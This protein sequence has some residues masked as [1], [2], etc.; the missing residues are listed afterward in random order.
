MKV[1]VDTNVIIDVLERRED[2]FQDSYDLLQLTVLGAI[3]ALM[4]TSAVTDVYYIIRRGIHDTE[5]AKEAII[6]L[7]ALVGLCDTIVSDINTALTLPIDDF[8]DAVLSAIAKR[9]KA[10]Y[11]ITRNEAD[12]KNSPVPAISPAMFLEQRKKTEDR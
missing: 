10:D 5:R 6:G 12:F 11:I 4:P 2:F 9:E 8:E 7:T 3:Q 1:L